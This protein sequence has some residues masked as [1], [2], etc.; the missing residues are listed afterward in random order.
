MSLIKR[1]PNRLKNFDYSQK[2]GYFITIC[3]KDKQEMLWGQCV[4]ADSIRPNETSHLSKYGLAIDSAI[5]DISKHY[6]N[7]L[8]NK[9]IIMPNHIHIILLLGVDSGRILS[10]PTKVVSIIIGQMKRYVSKQIGFSLWQKT[11]HDHVIRDE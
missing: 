11:Y 3:V 10:A 5:R 8:V 6:P 4:G 1:K 9:Y 2:G 7:V